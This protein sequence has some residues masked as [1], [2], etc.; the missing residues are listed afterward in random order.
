VKLILR[1]RFGG[2]RF[3]PGIAHQ[4]I[5]Y[6]EVVAGSAAGRGRH[7]TTF[8]SASTVQRSAWWQ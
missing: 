4:Q 7:R 1:Q 3:F 2:K 5:H 8:F 6:G